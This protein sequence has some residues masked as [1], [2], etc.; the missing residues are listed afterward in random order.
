[1][2]QNTRKYRQSKPHKLS[3]RKDGVYYINTDPP[4]YLGKG[5][6]GQARYQDYVDAWYGE[7]KLAVPKRMQRQMPEAPPE[8]KTK[9]VG[10]H[11]YEGVWVD[12]K[13]KSMG[14]AGSMD[15]KL[16]YEQFCRDW[17]QEVQGLEPTGNFDFDLDVSPRELRRRRETGKPIYMQEL[18]A[19]FLSYARERYK[20][21]ER[22]DGEARIFTNVASEMMRYA[23]E[24]E[25]AGYGPVN[26]DDFG[27]AAVG[28]IVEMMLKSTKE[29][30]EQRLAQGTINKYLRRIKAIC[31]WAN[32]QELIPAANWTRIETVPGIQ[33]GDRRVRHTP[34]MKKPVDRDDLLAALPHMSP[35]VAAM[36][37]VQYLCGCR[38]SEVIVLRPKDFN[39][40]AKDE[41]GQS[42]WSV[43]FDD[44]TFGQSGGLENKES[45]KDVVR[46]LYF[47]AE[48]QQILKPFMNR[49]KDARLFSPAEAAEWHKVQRSQARVTPHNCGNTRGSNVKSD[50]KRAPRTRYCLD[51]YRQA[52]ERACDRAGVPRWTP[53]RL[54]HLAATELAQVC[55]L[56]QVQQLL[57]HAD[58]RTT[59]KYIE[60]R[61][62][63]DKARKAASRLSLRSA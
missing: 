63:P 56:E 15:A 39:K 25:D 5:V 12:R 28:D 47:Y 53:G 17:Q 41:F 43:T 3:K 52:V 29:N 7:R 35:T 26:M 57:G 59:K 49:A 16:R 11:E 44:Q 60:D 51:T 6:K 40:R 10:K 31:K 23:K 33:K 22:G 36:V 34:G 50:P 45:H 54:R 18:L 62:G 4:T 55:D 61:L 30:G 20:A 24:Q 14:R 38:A 46:V 48:A 27:S 42:V 8:L 1:M 21:N 19:S 32:H 37:R 2:T 58:P 13:W 9:K